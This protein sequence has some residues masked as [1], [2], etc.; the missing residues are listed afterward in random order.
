[1][2]ADLRDARIIRMPDLYNVLGLSRGAS[3]AAIKAAYYRLAKQFHPDANAGVPAEQSI[4]DINHAYETLGNPLTRAV[5]DTALMRAASVARRRFWQSVATGVTTFALTLSSFPVLMSWTE[6]SLQR[7]LMPRPGIEQAAEPALDA[8]VVAS[9]SAQGSHSVPAP[10]A[11]AV[12]RVAA[13]IRIAMATTGFVGELPQSAAPNAL[14]A[15]SRAEI[16]DASLAENEALAYQ[17]ADR[18][19]GLPIPPLSGASLV[20][21]AAAG[22]AA[23]SGAPVRWVLHHNTSFGF[24]LKYPADLFPSVGK[25]FDINDRLLV[26]G[27]GRALMRIHSEQNTAGVTIA[28]YRAALVAGRYAG[29]VLDYAPQRDSWF[30]LSGTLGEEMFY[31]RVTFSCDRRSLHGWLLTYP[32][33]ERTLY[34]G[35]VEEIHRSYRHGN[36]PGERCGPK[37][38]LTRLRNETAG[39][40]PETDVMPF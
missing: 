38:Q 10:S 19:A 7:A 25:S 13:G 26:S 5:Y 16:A 9:Q 32:V 36:L 29:A 14:P 20:V 30:V 12:T 40:D 17:A 28:K 15:P 39:P 27:D 21:T 34:D 35:I 23:R 31:E 22:P 33:S 2:G 18:P 37:T 3:G 4:R 11:E 24:A 6:S 8:G 1:M